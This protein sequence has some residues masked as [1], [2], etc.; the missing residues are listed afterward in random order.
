MDSFYKQLIRCSQT[1][2]RDEDVVTL[3]NCS[4]SFAELSDLQLAMCASD[5]EE[6]IHLNTEETLEKINRSTGNGLDHGL[7][8]LAEWRKEDKWLRFDPYSKSLLSTDD[9]FTLISFRTLT[10]FAEMYPEEAVKC[11]FDMGY[12]K[13]ESVVDQIKRRRMTAR[14]L[15]EL[16]NDYARCHEDYEL[17]FAENTPEKGE[18]I[19]FGLA[20]WEEAASSGTLNTNDCWLYEERLNGMSCVDSIDNPFKVLDASSM[21]KL[22]H[23]V[24]E[25][26][27]SY[28]NQHYGILSLENKHDSESTS[29][30]FD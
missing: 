30:T 14:Q 26:E 17:R 5:W 28:V 12:L 7:I 13:D 21:R 10:R 8:D 19:G 6:V 4:L 22:A 11:G 9:P 29:R 24:Q 27:P 18:E 25:L 16:V 1:R 20:E 15:V 2:E 3:W 23:W